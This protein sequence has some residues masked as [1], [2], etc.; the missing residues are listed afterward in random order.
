ML[1]KTYRSFWEHLEVLDVP[2]GLKAGN[3]RAL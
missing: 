2:M 3:I 1:E